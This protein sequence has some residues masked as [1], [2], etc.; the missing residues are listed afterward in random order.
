[1]VCD[2]DVNTIRSGEKR[3]GAGRG[4]RDVGAVTVG[5]GIGGALVLDGQM[6]RGHNW[7]V[8]HFG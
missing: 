3:F 6:V 8:G 2:N 5:T 7:A 4:Y 1:M